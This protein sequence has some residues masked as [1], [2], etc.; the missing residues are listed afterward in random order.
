MRI[1]LTWAVIRLDGFI[2]GGAY[3]LECGGRVLC[4]SGGDIGFV[5]RIAR[6]LLCW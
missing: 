4:L 1:V 2:G 6:C 5:V 3:L